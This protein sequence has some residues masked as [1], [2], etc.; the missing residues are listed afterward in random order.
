MMNQ[1]SDHTGPSAVRSAAS[2]PG[3]CLDAP[4]DRGLDLLNGSANTPQER[5][6]ACATL[7]MTAQV[8]ML[9]VAQAGQTRRT[10]R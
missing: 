5:S 10:P 9:S 3:G 2:V 8:R 7:L 6:F 4:S 1:R